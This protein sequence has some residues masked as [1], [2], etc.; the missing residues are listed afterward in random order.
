MKKAGWGG[1]GK[2]LLLAPSA[3]LISV[4]A[5]DRGGVHYRDRVRDYDY[6]RVHVPIVVVVS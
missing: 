5:H 6:V 2:N 1:E 3:R 4:V